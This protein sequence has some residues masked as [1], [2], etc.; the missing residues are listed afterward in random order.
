MFHSGTQALIDH[1]AALP[2]AGRIPTRSAFQPLALGVRVPQLFAADRGAHGARFRLAGE[3]VERLH[4]QP[5]RGIDWLDLWRRDSRPLVAASI[6]QAFRE[7]RPV[8]L[9]AEATALDGVLEIVIAPLRGAS[10]AADRLI[11]LYQP[12]KAVDRRAEG[13]GL[14]G[15]RLAIG[16]GPIE[17]PRLT[18]AAVGGRRIA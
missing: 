12:A 7:A 1:W 5:L 14:L 15:A 6:V 13:V 10:G 8:V 17:R 18:L 11:G 4:G 3:G 16:V 2:G 9:L